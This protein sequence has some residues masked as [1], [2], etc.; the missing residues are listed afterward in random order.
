M[1]YKKRLKILFQKNSNFRSIYQVLNLI[2]Y[3]TFY[4]TIDLYLIWYYNNNFYE[5]SLSELNLNN[6]YLQ[7]SWFDD[8]LELHNICMKH[9]HAF[10]NVCY[11]HNG[12]RIRR[13]G[14]RLILRCMRLFVVRC[15]WCITLLDEAWQLC[16]TCI[17]H[18]SACILPSVSPS[19]S[20]AAY[21]PSATYSMSTNNEDCPLIR[22]FAYRIA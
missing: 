13:N 22:W 16:N 5:K 8:F 2:F 18:I 11:T 15:S 20:Y 10:R 1:Q 6:R 3:L 19:E 21:L 14:D 9:I 4:K 17:S 7:V 12:M